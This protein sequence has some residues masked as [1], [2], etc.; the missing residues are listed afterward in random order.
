MTLKAEKSKAAVMEALL[1]GPY[2]PGAMDPNAPAVHLLKA[3]GVP[4]ITRNVG[5]N[6]AAVLCHELHDTTLTA[7]QVKQA[8][9]Q[10][11][12]A[13]LQW[14][15]HEP[16][17]NWPDLIKAIECPFARDEAAEYLRGIMQRARFVA[18]LQ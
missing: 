7:D 18:S 11:L 12:T 6:S 13:A 9:Q 8:R 5:K 3:D 10:G 4:I 1:A 2:T 14:H 17:K 15:R 16:P